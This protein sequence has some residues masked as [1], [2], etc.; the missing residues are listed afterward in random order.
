MKLEEIIRDVRSTINEATPRFYDDNDLIRWIN[1][2][3]KDVARKSEFL[4]VKTTIA[5]TAGTSEYTMPADILRA[6]VIQFVTTASPTQVYK[7]QYV[8]IQSVDDFYGM[9]PSTQGPPVLYTLFGFPPN[10]KVT[11][12]PTPSEDGT[13]TVYY[14]QGPDVIDTP[15]S[16]VAIPDTWADLIGKYATYR[17]LLKD[18]DPAWQ[19][20][21]SIYDN[22]LADMIALT[23]RFSDQAGM[24]TAGS[25]SLVPR[26]L[27]DWDY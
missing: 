21:K 23:R 8:D 12:Y 25:G 15:S 26:H 10:L 3:I 1:E 11:L 16:D 7:L 19:V 9:T 4:Q 17:A 20:F 13:L 22:D 2:A 18:R 14:Y 6:T 5:V 24:V 27:W